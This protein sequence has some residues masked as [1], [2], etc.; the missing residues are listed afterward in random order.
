MSCITKIRQNYEYFTQTEKKIADY[1]I[2][3][4]KDVINIST[5]DLA[6]LTKTS[7]ASIVR[8]SRSLGFDGFGELKIELVKS[9]QSFN[10]EEIDT[11]LK[12]DDTVEEMVQKIEG[13]VQNTLEETV[14]LINFKNLQEALDSIKKAETIYLL[15]VGA[16]ALVAMDLQQKLLRINRRCVF[17]LDSNLGLATSVHITEK[18]VVIA[19]SYGGRTKEVNLA[20]KRAR[21][22]GAK[23]IAITKWGK[24]P[25]ASLS[26]I[27]I[28]LP[29]NEGELRIGAINSRF[30][31]LLITDIIYLGIA[32]ENFELTEHH[33]RE[34]K[35]IVQP[36]KE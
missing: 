9:L 29:N 32:K 25:L 3:N 34:T 12:H 18:D 2:E 7:P 26:H 24:T 5:Q 36:L 6:E 8:F 33:L 17:S 21:D 19:I 20:V 28:F 22:N 30:A 35:K 23:C 11:I 27:S 10:D 13:R 1:V 16:S 31:Q 15:G 14:R 4:S